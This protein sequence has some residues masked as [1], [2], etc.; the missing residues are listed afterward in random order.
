MQ[1]SRSANTVHGAAVD[2]ALNGVFEVGV[3]F[4]II[5]LG[6]R[7]QR[8]DDGPSVGAA[9][10][11]GEQVILAPQRHRPDGALHRIGVEFDA[12]VTEEEAQRR[13]ARERIAEGL[14]QPTARRH[15]AQLSLQPGFQGVDQRPQAGVAD[16]LAFRRAAATDLLLDRVELGDSMQGLGADHSTITGAGPA[17]GGNTGADCSGASVSVTGRKVGPGGVAGVSSFFQENNN[18]VPTPYFLATPETDAPSRQVSATMRL[19]SAE[20]G[21]SCMSFAYQFPNCF[22]GSPQPRNIRV[23]SRRYAGSCPDVFARTIPVPSVS[24]P[25]F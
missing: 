19:L 25:P 21:S 14:G 23:D 16:I 8:G 2:H 5:E 10:G 22:S 17:A 11:S 3:G 1:G 15:P 18:R 4:D 12:A 9:I 20:A 7:E 6:R 13:P 24:Q